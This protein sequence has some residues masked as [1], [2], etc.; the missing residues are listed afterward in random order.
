MV[1]ALY[2][3]HVYYHVRQDLK[4][5]QVPLPHETGF[6]AAYNPYSSEEFLK[7]CEDYGILHDPLRYRDENVFGLINKVCNG[8]M[9]IQ[10]K[11][12]WLVGSSK[13]L[14]A[15]PMWGSLKYQRV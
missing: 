9:I 4:R 11:A 6:N 12:Q 5:L 13:N 1:K 15:L 14:S 2:R 8:Q 3:F 7:I 10:A